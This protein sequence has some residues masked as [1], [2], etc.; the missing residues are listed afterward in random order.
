MGRAGVLEQCKDRNGM[1]GWYWNR[2]YEDSS[3]LY[4]RDERIKQEFDREPSVGWTKE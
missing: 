1:S 2:Y 4:R 3:G